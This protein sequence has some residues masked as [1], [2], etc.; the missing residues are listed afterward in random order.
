MFNNYELTR[1][2]SKL[3][4][5]AFNFSDLP[6]MPKPSLICLPVENYTLIHYF[7]Y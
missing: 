5:K 4:L 2:L 6:K 7:D 3:F 1:N